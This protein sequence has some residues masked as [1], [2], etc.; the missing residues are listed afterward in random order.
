MQAEAAGSALSCA[1]C[2]PFLEI[3]KATQQR[4]HLYCSKDIFQRGTL[5]PF[6][7]TLHK[8]TVSRSSFV[9]W[10]YCHVNIDIYRMKIKEF[11][12]WIMYQ[13]TV[14]H[15]KVVPSWGAQP[16][17]LQQPDSH[18]TGTAGSRW[19]AVHRSCVRT[20]LCTQVAKHRKQISVT[21]PPIC[22]HLNAVFLHRRTCFAKSLSHSF[23]N[24]SRTQILMQPRTLY[25]PRSPH[26]WDLSV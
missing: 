8:Q 15:A 20:N 5:P 11:G 23:E 21:P 22:C 2:P 3:H 6:S 9:S 19:Q 24:A 13:T 14:P 4:L 16:R 17:V 1:R 25:T 10:Q 12:M 7:Q 18:E 26:K